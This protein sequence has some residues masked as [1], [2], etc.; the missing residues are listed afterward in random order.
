MP[1]LPRENRW[2]RAITWALWI[3]LVLSIPVT[4]APQVSAFLGE[5]AV[6]P[7]SLIPLVGLLLIWFIP[8]LARG[9]RLPALSWPFL[10]FVGLAILSAAAAPAL[11]IFPVNGQDLFSREVRALATVGLSLGFYWTA[12]VLPQNDDDI[13]ASLRAVSVGG[14]VMLVWSTVQAWV[15]LSGRTHVPL[16]LTDVHHVFS[17]RDPLLDRVT[18]FSFEPSWLGDQLVVLYLPLWLSSVF[19]RVS[20][21]SK[22]RRVLS[23]ELLLF[24]WGMAIL[25]LTKSR[26][27]LLSLS[28]VALLAFVI[29]T[30]RAS[31]RLVRKIVSSGAAVPPERRV[32]VLHI[33]FQAASLAA[34]AVVIV[35]GGV[36]AGRVDRRL[37][38]LSNLPDLLPE[39]RHY[40]PH[41]ELYEV[42]NRLSFAERVVYWVDGFRVFEQYPIMGVG[43]GNAGFFFEQSLP[44]YGYRL[45]EIQ[46][47]VAPASD[48]FPNTKNLW[49]RLLAETGVLG[50]SAFA[51]WL[52][53]LGLVAW[54]AWKRGSPVRSLIG[55]AALIALL[56]EVG[57][58]FSLDS[59]ALPQLWVM[60][61]LLTAAIWRRE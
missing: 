10:A 32:A 36:F 3:L 34:V 5:N 4:S 44:G 43:L 20:A 28:L 49:V 58:G 13:T 7:L 2:H 41:D 46:S 57:E 15:I 47:V 51:V 8:Y 37:R 61:G 19:R 48:T 18:G 55:L 38:Q 39:I 17:I 42:A 52:G 35:A 45:T 6:S 1:P 30:W 50:F 22:S 9:G 11:P 54:T 12:S 53:L 31:G 26:I 60:L 40:F 59:F 14:I 56:A 24:L 27:S 23:L 33:L 16:W 21:F 29:V 25:L